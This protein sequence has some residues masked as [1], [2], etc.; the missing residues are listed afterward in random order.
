MSWRRFIERARASEHAVQV[1]DGLDELTRSVGAYLA[2][3]FAAGQP[4]IVIASAGHTRAFEAELEARGVRARELEQ[5]GM[6]TCRDADETLAAFMDGGTPSADRFDAAVG[7]LVDE[8][9]AHFPGT[10][11]RA[12]GEMVDILWARGERDGALALE[13]LWNDL[14]RTRRFALLCGYRLDIFDIDVQ[15]GALPA[16]FGAHS[17]AQPVYDTARLADAVDTALTEI[18]GAIDAAHIYLDVA[19]DAP[20][21]TL[22]RGQAV[23]AWL[24]STDAELAETVLGRARHH[25]AHA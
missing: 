18:V 23:L 8:V 11:I 20:L 6:L 17:H 9:S 15:T 21:R 10:T 25:Y 2:A 4:A 12:F 1:Y 13:E 19:A 5:A 24:S 3:G 16:V 7:A 14:A 22:P